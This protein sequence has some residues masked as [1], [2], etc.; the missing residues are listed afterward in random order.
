MT[1]NPQRHNCSCLCKVKSDGFSKPP[2]AL[3]SPHCSPS[4]FFFYYVPWTTSRCFLQLQPSKKLQKESESVQL[5][6]CRVEVATWQGGGGHVCRVG[7]G[8]HVSSWGCSRLQAGPSPLPPCAWGLGAERQGRGATVHEGQ[9]LPGHCGL[10]PAVGRVETMAGKEQGIA[11]KISL[12]VQAAL[13]ATPSCATYTCGLGATSPPEPLFPRP[14]GWLLGALI[15][16]SLCPLLAAGSVSPGPRHLGQVWSRKTQQS[17]TRRG[18]QGKDL[19]GGPGFPEAQAGKGGR[20]KEAASSEV[21]RLGTQ[22]VEAQ[23]IPERATHEGLWR[24]RSS[25]SRGRGDL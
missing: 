19:E 9:P 20:G 17:L 1:A 5:P 21:W 25:I 4:F 16:T 10:G 7:G 24:S 23:G 15:K 22:A 2:P 12:W 14:S 6:A 11:V 18:L 3:P 8:D 13:G